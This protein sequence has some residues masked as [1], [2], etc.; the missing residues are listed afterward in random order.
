MRS[1][2][3]LLTVL[4]V[5]S[6]PALSCSKE[7]TRE[8]A[9]GPEWSAWNLQAPGA[10]EDV[11][12][13]NAE[14]ARATMF[15]RLLPMLQEILK[16]QGPAAAISICGE[17]APAI[18][19]EVGEEL[20]LRIGRSGVRLRNPVNTGPEWAADGIAQSTKTKMVWE[21]RDGTLGVLTPIQTASSC[22]ICHGGPEDLGEGV[23]EALAEH[24]PEDAATG[25]AEGDLRGW[26][27]VES[28]PVADAAD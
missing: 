24:Y 14:R 16:E 27:W 26:F 8:V 17:Q 20:G 10:R 3:A 5:L 25:F 21:N 9:E 2:A 6:L 18:A 13:M 7:A 28:P 22:L 11:R 12:L 19:L 15:N 23:A 4:T 1:I